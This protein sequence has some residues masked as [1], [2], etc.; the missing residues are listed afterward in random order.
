MTSNGAIPEEGFL[1]W[2]EA[3]KITTKRVF[4]KKYGKYIEYLS[5]IPYDETMRIQAAIQGKDREATRQRTVA[6][7]KRVMINPPLTDETAR[8]LGKVDTAV[9]TEILNDVFSAK[10]AQEALES[11]GNESDG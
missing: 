11:L 7:L 6:I 4:V 9:I 3:A 8:M 2:D 5:M 10:E 1:T